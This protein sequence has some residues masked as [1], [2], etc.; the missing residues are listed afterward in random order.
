M[1]IYQAIETRYLGPTNTRGGRIKARA[2]AGSVT[3]PYN[4][5]LNADQNHRAAAMAL[6]AKCAKHAEQYGGKSIWS[7]GVW[8]QGG[9]AK[10]DGYVFTVT[11]PVEA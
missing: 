4:H 8:T 1:T 11:A 7:E 6:A 5:E 3:V 9:N 2:W 10:G